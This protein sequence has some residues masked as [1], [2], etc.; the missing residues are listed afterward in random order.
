MN[1]FCFL[2]FL[3]FGVSAG[4]WLFA[5]SC[6]ISFLKVWASAT[7]RIS[8]HGW[9]FLHPGSFTNLFFLCRRRAAGDSPCFISWFNGLACAWKKQNGAEYSWKGK[10]PEEFTPFYFWLFRWSFF[11]M[12]RLWSMWSFRSS[13]RFI[14][15]N[16]LIQLKKCPADS[17]LQNKR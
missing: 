11:F 6:M 17:C 8:R 15:S 13:A 2:R 5:S 3:I 10:K 1:R 9:F 16:S 14:P 7:A 4:I 12:I